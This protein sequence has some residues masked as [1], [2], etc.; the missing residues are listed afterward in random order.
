MDYERRRPA[1][2]AEPVLTTN[3]AISFIAANIRLVAPEW[4][5]ILNRFL[6]TPAFAR[7]KY[8]EGAL[9]SRLSELWAAWAIEELCDGTGITFVTDPI[10]QGL[11]TPNFWFF[12]DPEGHLVVSDRTTG[13]TLMDIDALFVIDDVPLLVEVKLDSS[14]SRAGVSGSPH[15]RGI[16][17]FLRVD[18]IAQTTAPIREYFDAPCAYLVIL[19]PEQIRP[20]SLVQQRF[21]AA[22][23]LIAPFYTNKPQYLLDLGRLTDAYPY[24]QPS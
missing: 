15:R 7:R 10:R 17:R 11:Q 2:D 18:H 13:D 9:A 8:D 12:R 4:K 3:D 24:L 23:G 22:G 21:L 1:L 6:L 16:D 19:A 5:P 20:D 14:R